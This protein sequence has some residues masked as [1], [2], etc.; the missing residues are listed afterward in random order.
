MKVLSQQSQLSGT[1]STIDNA[2]VVRLYNETAGDKECHLHD[3]EGN[4]YG[5]ITIPPQKVEYIQ[6]KPDEY[7]TGSIG[8]K[9]SK[10]AYSHVMQY[11]SWVEGGGGAPA[12]W[13][14][15]DTAT[16]SQ[17]N[18]W[19]ITDS[20]AG[21]YLKPDGSKIFYTNKGDDNIYT[22]RQVDLLI[23]WDL[24]SGTGISYMTCDSPYPRAMDIH[25]K[26][27]G[28]VLYYA[29]WDT[30]HV[31]QLSLSTPWDVTTSS[32]TSVLDIA[33]TTAEEKLRGL[34]ISP[35]G[36]K[37]F[38]HGF[39][40][41]KI[42]RFDLGISWD[43]ASI[44]GSYHSQSASI[45]DVP[46]G[47]FFKSDGTK[48]FSTDNTGDVVKQWNLSTPWD[49]TSVT[50]SSDS[51]LNVSTQTD[52]PTGLYISDDGKYIFL[53]DSDSDRIIRYLLNP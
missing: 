49:I 35:D 24:T 39:D 50:S 21:I 46:L 1:Q 23:P 29:D 28:T 12:S 18:S 53:G 40:E 42:F 30:D 41:D 37:L 8:L 19:N 25:F 31:V 7:L 33:A 43:I 9:C 26:P 51:S 17:V 22:I 15:I 6:K 45:G 48:V 27:D 11:A 52:T 34:Y 5:T 38:V 36:G 2:T 14:N 4:Q 32:Q 20:V 47:L 10:I 13:N 44:T 3:S 16:Y